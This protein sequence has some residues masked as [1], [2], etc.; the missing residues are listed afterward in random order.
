MAIPKFFHCFNHL[1]EGDMV[2]LDDSEARHAS[3]SR[4]LSANDAVILLNGKGEKAYGYFAELDKR[5]AKVAIEKVETCS[6]PKRNVVV[7]SAI[8]KGDR[9]KVMLDMLTQLGISGFIPLKCDFS[10]THLSEK[11]TSK[12]QKV[13]IEACKQSENP[14]LPIIH[15]ELDLEQLIDSEFWQTHCAIRAE[16]KQNDSYDAN[17]VA[18][19][20]GAKNS[21]VIIGPEGGF[22]NRET[23]LLDSDS[24]TT[25]S[26][27][28][29]ILRTE[30]AAIA[31]V[32]KLMAEMVE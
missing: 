23:I 3:Q 17:Q 4:R 10:V 16:K 20:L 24:S 15:S 7:A 25:F 6:N 1:E 13:A 8:P 11:L 9:Q 22:S 28:D 2:K 26:I 29:H 12:W 32:S 31:V 14:F 18:K 27:G 19:F 5:I 30:T 21:L